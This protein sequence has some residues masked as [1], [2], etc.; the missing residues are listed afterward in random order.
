MISFH[1]L[2]TICVL[3]FIAL[4][5][6]WSFGTND[7]AALGRV[8]TNVPNPDKEGEFMDVDTITSNPYPLQTLVDEKFR[9]V[10]IAAG[11]S[12]A[13]AI[14]AEGELRVWGSFR[15]SVNFPFALYIVDLRCM[16]PYHASFLA[17]DFVE[18]I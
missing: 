7:D 11:D 18:Q 4:N 1:V 9:T 17:R 8:T 5:Q 13:A 14:S 6:V 3:T 2:N 10:R 12:I 16:H 15:V